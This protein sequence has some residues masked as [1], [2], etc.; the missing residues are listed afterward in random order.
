MSPDVRQ[1]IVKTM[2]WLLFSTLIAAVVACATGPV[3]GGSTYGITVTTK[4][5]TLMVGK[6][7]EFTYGPHS[8]KFALNGGGGT[9]GIYGYRD[10]HVLKL[11]WTT[12][13]RA[14]RQEIIEIKPLIAQMQTERKIRRF[15]GLRTLLVEINGVQLK[16]SY[17]IIPRQGYVAKKGARRKYPL[18]ESASN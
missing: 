2:Q 4:E 13:S 5:N 18:Y 3:P 11:K 6:G 14:E 16:I 17:E 8:R 9:G 7:G 15:E 12:A 10:F 1:A